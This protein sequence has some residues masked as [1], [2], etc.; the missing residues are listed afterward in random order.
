M[1]FIDIYRIPRMF[2]FKETLLMPSPV[3]PYLPQ[4]ICHT[5]TVSACNSM[6]QSCAKMG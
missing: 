3:P 2:T 5:Q 1:C 6:L 4:Q